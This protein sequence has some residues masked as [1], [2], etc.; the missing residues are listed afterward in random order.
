MRLENDLTAWS[1]SRWSTYA[2][3]PRQAYYRFVKKIPEK[4]S[5]A[6]NRGLDVHKSCASYLAGKTNVVIPEIKNF[7]ETMFNRLREHKP[8]VEVQLAFTDQWKTTGWFDKNCWLRVVL[9]V[10]KYYNDENGCYALVIDHKT[11]KV[12]DEY[13]EQMEIFSVAAML[14]YER[15]M[16]NL[17]CDM[18][19]ARLWYLDAGE[20]VAEEIVYHQMIEIQEKWEER[21]EKLL[22]DTKFPPRPS[23]LCEWCSFS[24]ANGGPCE[25]G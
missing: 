14:H 24:S 11:G 4:K 15:V 17:S 9:D 20:E 25:Y 1:F 6:A 3:C 16:P 19:D 23:R 13:S 8:Q 21:A 22:T 2:K 12:R 18:V 7:G 10:S 5:F